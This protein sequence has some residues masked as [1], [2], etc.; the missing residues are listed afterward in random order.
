MKPQSGPLGHQLSAIGY[1]PRRLSRREFLANSALLT[2]SAAV[3]GCKTSGGAG[4]AEPI[5]DIHQHL[6]YSG[7]SDEVLLAATIT[8]AKARSAAAQA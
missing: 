4:D 1:Q 7:R 6:G 8:T 3:P 2:L 5:I